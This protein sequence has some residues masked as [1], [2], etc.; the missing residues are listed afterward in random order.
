MTHAPSNQP[1][2]LVLGP[3]RY[4][5]PLGT[6]R[7]LGRL[8]VR[9]YG[10]KHR[11]RSMATTSRYCAGTVDVGVDG[12]PWGDADRTVDE[13]LKAGARLGQGTVL[14][15][16]SDEWSVLVA[17][18]S[19][20][21]SRV[22]RM[23]LVSSRIVEELAAKD[24]LQR[25]AAAHGLPTPRIVFPT[26]RAEAV[27]ESGR[28]EYPVMLKPIESR[29]DVLD[30]AVVANAEELLEAYARMEETPEAP[31]VMFQEYIPGG[32]RDVW[33]FNGYFDAESRCLAAFTGVKVRQHPAKM[34]IASLGELRQND[35]VIRMTCDFMR[36]VAYR[37]IVDIGYRFDARDGLYKVLDI[38]PRLGGAFRMFV[39]DSGM[40]VVR[41]MYLD[42]TGRP[43]SPVHATDGR[44]WVHETAD[45]V[46]AR[47]YAR[48]DG[49]TFGGWLRSLRAVREGVAWANDDPLPFAVAISL[50]VR[51][52]VIAR[53]RQVSRRA[54]AVIEMRPSRSKA[55]RTAA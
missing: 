23:P 16:G 17:R 33:I 10:V 55:E 50:L 51:E 40:D 4:A 11:T 39:D 29:P 48:L 35:T 49:L 18:H 41:A 47:R 30:K 14:I 12:R 15:P 54:R 28:L 52:T 22:F 31:N 1:A 25:L 27:I 26:N 43:V 21:L 24:G 7:S 44:R 38:N 6:M 46:A 45:L 20:Q 3:P 36:A 5:G 32:D 53:W 13:L 19:E 9:V 37:G 42:L 8:G 34:G 2:V